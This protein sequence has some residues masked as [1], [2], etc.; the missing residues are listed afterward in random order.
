MGNGASSSRRVVAYVSIP[1]VKTSN[2][3]S[4][5]PENISYRVGEIYN[6]LGGLILIVSNYIRD[7]DFP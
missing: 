3:S 4:R 1:M 6:I 5:L 2:I 7:R